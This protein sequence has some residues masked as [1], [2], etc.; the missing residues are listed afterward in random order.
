MTSAWRSPSWYVQGPGLLDSIS[1]HIPTHL[2]RVAVVA[3][4]GRLTALG[5]VLSSSL[6]DRARGFLGFA[7]ECSD[8]EISRLEQEV[9]HLDVDALVAVG[10]GK[11]LDT[12]KAVGHRVD[13]DT[14]AVPTI[15]AT[16][17]PTAAAAIVYW[18]NGVFKRVELYPRSP[19]SVLVDTD[20]VR[21]APVRFLVSGMGDAIA[22]WFEADACEQSGATTVA[23]G[24]PT[25]AALAVA[26]RCYEVLTAEGPQAVADMSGTETTP[27]IEKVIEANT[28]LSGVGFESGGL[29]AAHSIHNG[30]TAIEATHSYYHGEKV[31]F[32]TICQ[33]LMQDDADRAGEIAR[34]NAS[35]GLPTC[36]VDLGIDSY[37]EEELGRIAKKSCEE[38]ESIHNMPFAV[39]PEMVI[40]AIEAAD[41]LGRAI[42]GE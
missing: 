12:A 22:T 16:D 21:A 41:R 27:S 1:D 42:S 2:E 31:A 25:Q 15:A 32:A 29:A 28:L 38:Q 40:E 30:L 8:E 20:V 35:V 34:F 10:G 3:T 39:S 19:L 18:P 13:I 4:S 9:G 17:A 23:G 36:L 26:R 14:I 6:G 37:G 33:L 24:S 7:G 5:D 11:T